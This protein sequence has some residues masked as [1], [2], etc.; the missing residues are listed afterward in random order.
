MHLVK[1]PLQE[2]TESLRRQ[3][4]D[5][6]IS[7]LHNDHR[8]HFADSNHRYKIAA[9]PDDPDIDRQWAWHTIEAFKAWN[10]TTGSPEIVIGIVDTGADLTH[11]DLQP[12]LVPGYDFVKHNDVPQDKNGHGTHVSGTAGADTNNDIGGAGM[13]PQC[14]IMPVRVLD[15]SGQGSLFNVAKG[16]VWA[17]DHGAQVINLSLGGPGTRGLHDAL[18]YA[19]NKGAFLACAAGNE[20]TNKTDLAYPGAYSKCFSVASTTESDHRSGY[21]NF[22]KWVSV[23]APGSSI[24]SDWL[25]NGYSTISGTSMATP[26]VAGLAGL[27]ASQALNNTQ[28]RDRICNTA[29][30]IGDTGRYWKC[31]RINAD[32]AVN[33]TTSSAHPQKR[34]HRPSK[35]ARSR[36][37]NRIT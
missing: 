19:W 22:G 4:H 34:K 35:P 30:R 8:V 15:K 16:V 2:K 26:H 31:G 23:A 28:I 27:L 32:K 9:V 33:D 14:S 37:K 5:K 6:H 7:R 24:F 18:Q 17:A 1:F 13:C 11:P 36:G 25:N 12:K 3:A 21:S 10:T 29:D 20:D